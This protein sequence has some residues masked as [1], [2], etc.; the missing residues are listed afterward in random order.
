MPGTLPGL[1]IIITFIHASR[2]LQHS[3]F[4]STGDGETIKISLKKELIDNYI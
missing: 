2:N 1:P 4:I 3:S